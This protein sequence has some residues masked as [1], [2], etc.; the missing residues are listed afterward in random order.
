M[1][2]VIYDLTIVMRQVRPHDVQLYVI[3]VLPAVP[4]VVLQI[5]IVVNDLR[6]EDGTVLL[7][8]VIV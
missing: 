7:E 2:N 5:T 8:I 3:I 4:L 1:S 6:Q